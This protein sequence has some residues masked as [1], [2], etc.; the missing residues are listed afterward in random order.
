[1]L[2]EREEEEEGGAGAVSFFLPRV[3]F[4]FLGLKINF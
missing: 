3:S 4:F 1:L 2:A